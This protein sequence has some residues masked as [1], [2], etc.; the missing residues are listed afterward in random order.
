MGVRCLDRGTISVLPTGA[1]FRRYAP[2]CMER[3]ISVLG[4]MVGKVIID[5]MGLPCVPLAGTWSGQELCGGGDGSCDD[6]NSTLCRTFFL[7]VWRVDQSSSCRM[8]EVCLCMLLTQ[9]AAFLCPIQNVRIPDPSYKCFVC[10][11][12]FL[13]AYLE[14]SLE[15]P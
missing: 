10:F 5:V 4:A 15:K 11:F 8:E 3:I 6:S 1:I 7:L 2:G 14:V 13:F 9:R 12:H